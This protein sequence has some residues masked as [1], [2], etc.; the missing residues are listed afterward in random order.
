MRPV[1]KSLIK[2]LDASIF[3]H[4]LTLGQADS[5]KIVQPVSYDVSDSAANGI[6]FTDM[7]KVITFPAYSAVFGSLG[8]LV[9]ASGASNI[10]AVKATMGLIASYLSCIPVKKLGEE[11]GDTSDV[12]GS[13]EVSDEIVF[14]TLGTTNDGKLNT[15][16]GR[17]SCSL[18]GSF[19]GV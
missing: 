10:Q 1:N 18:E 11:A 15:V 2:W 7:W 3:M 16:R 8:I 17:I 4:I 13:L 19:E 14:E 9:K 5:L 12:I 6:I